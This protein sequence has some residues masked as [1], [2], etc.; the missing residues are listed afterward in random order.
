MRLE[1]GELE[2]EAGQRTVVDA[3]V[4]PQHALVSWCLAYVGDPEVRSYSFYQLDRPSS[5]I[6]K[7]KLLMTAQMSSMR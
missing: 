5:W 2:R 4:N 6:P 3:L 7:E 1:S